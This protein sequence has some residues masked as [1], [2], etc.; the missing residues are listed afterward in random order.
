MIYGNLFA[1]LS[2]EETR[3]S[4]HKESYPAF[5]DSSWPWIPVSKEEPHR[6]ARPFYNAWL[7]FTTA[8]DFVWVES[9]DTNEAPDRRIRR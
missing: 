9:W 6:A 2:Q 5:G 1:R 7:N 3:W 8:K 4:E